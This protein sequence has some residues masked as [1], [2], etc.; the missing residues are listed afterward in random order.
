MNCPSFCD[1]WV[2]VP[3]A[4]ASTFPRAGGGMCQ[5]EPRWVWYTDIVRNEREGAEIA[6]LARNI[7]IGPRQLGHSV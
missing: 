2:I 7:S 3:S 4:G 1:V 5:E 6:N